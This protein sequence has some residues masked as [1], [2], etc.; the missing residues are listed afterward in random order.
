MTEGRRPWHRLPRE[1][2]A[3]P[4]QEVSKVRGWGKISFKTKPF[5]DSLESGWVRSVAK[6]LHK[7]QFQWN[8]LPTMGCRNMLCV[9][10]TGESRGIKTQ[11][12]KNDVQILSII[13]TGSTHT[14]GKEKELQYSSSS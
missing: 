7:P 10:L 4:S 3:A 9:H 8:F 13:K 11:S 6:G 2:V 5:Y 14:R 12:K 1:A